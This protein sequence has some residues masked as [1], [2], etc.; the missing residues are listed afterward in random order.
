MRRIQANCAILGCFTPTAPSGLQLRLQRKASLKE[1]QCASHVHR[2]EAA[3]A[4][5]IR[6]SLSKRT[7]LAPSL[8]YR[9]SES[10]REILSGFWQTDIRCNYRIAI[11][12]VIPSEARPRRAESRDLTL[13]RP[14]FENKKQPTSDSS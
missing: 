14:A 9:A 1:N 7:K 8:T 12:S 4:R 3:S 11:Y 2:I 6:K 10:Q 13:G 5:Q